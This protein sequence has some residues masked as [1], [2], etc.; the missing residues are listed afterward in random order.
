MAPI[1]RSPVKTGLVMMR[2]RLMHDRE[3]LRLV[4][5]CVVLDAICRR[6]VGRAPAALIQRRD[7]PGMRPH[8]LQSFF[9]IAH[10][11]PRRPASLP[12]L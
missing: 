7:E 9:E 3:H 11:A 8:L 12:I 1:I 2:A 10:L 6:R 4:G 5:P